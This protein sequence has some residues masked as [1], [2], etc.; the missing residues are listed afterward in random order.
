MND[1]LLLTF[2][3]IARAASKVIM[4]I[5]NR[6]FAVETKKD[7]SPVTEADAAAEA[8]ILERLA[9][10]DPNLAVVAEE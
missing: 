7:S 1:P 8:L 2:V 5:Y 9:K 6:D 4:E 10:Y 3:D